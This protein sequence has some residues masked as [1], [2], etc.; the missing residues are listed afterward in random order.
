MPRRRSSLFILAVFCSFVVAAAIP[1]AVQA[2]PP[3]PSNSSGE[4]YF[5]P[6]IYF[7]GLESWE[8]IQK[9]TL[10]DGRTTYKILV[11][12]TTLGEYIVVLYT[13]FTGATALVALFMVT[14][15][16]LQW[17]LAGGN[18]GSIT[19]AK[20]TITGALA[21]MVIALLSYALLATI[22]SGLVKF[23]SLDTRLE[24]VSSN[25]AS[26]VLAEDITCESEG[27]D[28]LS[29][30]TSLNIAR[31]EGLS[32]GS[33]A[34]LKGDAI[35]GLITAGY[36]MVRNPLP[37]SKIKI[38]SA[39]RA[40]SFQAQLFEE[41]CSECKV[42]HPND[43]K[44]KCRSSDCNPPT[45]NPYLG[46]CPHTEGNAIDAF[47]DNGEHTGECQFKLENLMIENGFCRSYD[48]A[49]HFENPRM[50]A[51]CLGFSAIADGS[52]PFY[53][54]SC[55]SKTGENCATP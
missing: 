2:Q 23:K 13:F 24:A 18:Q 45:C 6:S 50:S 12:P 37:T 30:A 44:Q 20:E 34:C 51:N 28:S 47:C 54:D 49:W 40:R 19:K 21:G 25:T 43:W 53:P 29:R 10:S 36:A 4:V 9:R 32:E 52:R 17:L 14:Y 39:L 42:A 41:K 8:G 27:M 22:S 5:E 7:P 26:G 3:G 55:N 48:E 15:G 46:P 35:E 31:V 1:A 11:T 38:T 16:G 33:Y